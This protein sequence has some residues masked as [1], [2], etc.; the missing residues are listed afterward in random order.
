MVVRIWAEVGN[1]ACCTEDAYLDVINVGTT[2][3][4][5]GCGGLC[6]TVDDDVCGGLGITV[7]DDL[8]SILSNNIF[9]MENP[10]VIVSFIIHVITSSTV[11]VHV[12]LIR[13]NKRG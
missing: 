1:G 5:N 7:D 4:D 6:I 3:D 12:R 13:K 8:G 11:V 2:V 10:N 9:L